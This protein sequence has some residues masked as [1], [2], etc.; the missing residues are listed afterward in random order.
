M[1]KSR[2]TE[3]QIV[4][5]LEEAQGGTTTVE[6]CRRH[7]ISRKTFYLWRA[8]YG[9]LQ[10]SEVRRLKELETHIFRLEK[11]VARQAVELEAARE[12]IR[13]KW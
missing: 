7:G 6:I 2:F 10:G 1:R 4:S 11:V 9:G 13:G 8:R 3:N 12:I 5:I